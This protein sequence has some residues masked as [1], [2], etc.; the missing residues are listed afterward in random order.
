MFT[1]KAS[2]LHYLLFLKATGL[3]ATSAGKVMTM[4]C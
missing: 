4:I 1:L 2:T 3:K